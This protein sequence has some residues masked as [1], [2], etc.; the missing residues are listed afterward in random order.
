MAQGNTYRDRSIEATK[1]HQQTL[2]DTKRRIAKLYEQAAEDLAST[3]GKAKSS[4]TQQWAN[5]YIK[6]MRGRVGEL[7]QDVGKITHQGMSQEANRVVGVQLEWL[8]DAAQL[9]GLDLKN[10]FASTFAHTPDEAIASV[11]QGELYKG[12]KTILSKRIWNNEALQSGKIEDVILQGLAKQQ[13]PVELAKALQAYVNPKAAMP[14]NWN[15]TYEGCPF[16]L[17]VDYNAKRLAVTSV[18]HAKYSATIMLGR[19][20]PF[21]VGLQW[22]LSGFHLVYDICDTYM[23]HDEGLGIGVF[24][25][26]NA[27]MPHPFCQCTWYATE[28]NRSLEDIAQELYRW[29][30][31]ECNPKLDK[32]F[33]EW[34]GNGLLIQKQAYKT[35]YSNIENKWLGNTGNVQEVIELIDQANIVL[36]KA[37]PTVYNQIDQIALVP[38]NADVVAQAGIIKDSNRFA[39]M[40]N[41]SSW[42]SLSTIQERLANDVLTGHMFKTDDPKVLVAHEAGHLAI[43]RIALTRCGGDMNHFKQA[44]DQLIQ[45][46]YT[47]AFDQ[48]TYDE[49]IGAIEKELG[50]YAVSLPEEFPAQCFAAFFFGEGDYPIAN[51]VA[52]YYINLLNE[53]SL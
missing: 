44:Y 10:R 2:S 7:W 45:D 31:G 11:I 25:F 26:D 29:E 50:A 53:V 40:F 8:N 43:M 42:D 35:G 34:Q 28:G 22:E 5:T 1:L 47:A 9:A 6:D 19:K 4:L 24:A 20:D 46:A 48:E 49:I 14:D 23:E 37:L 41:T 52:T 36:E 18:N 32:A 33:G 21:A 51:K 16:P 13:S 30:Q 12:K 3:A 17:R 15:D 27:P 39:M 38:L